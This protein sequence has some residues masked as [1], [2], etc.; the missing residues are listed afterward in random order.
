[1][2]TLSERL[3]Q[4]M[5]I[6]GVKQVDVIQSTK[7]TKGALSSYITGRYTPKQ[8]KIYI[9]AKYFDVSEAWL[10]GYDVPMDRKAAAPATVQVDLEREELL[11]N[12]DLLNDEGKENLLNQSRIL[13][14]S[15]YYDR[16]KGS[17]ADFA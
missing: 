10:M 9:L 13:L 8:D 5:S 12:Y 15:G 3:R 7:I 11:R 2:A 6:R 4:I 1:M 14:K 16:L 17:E